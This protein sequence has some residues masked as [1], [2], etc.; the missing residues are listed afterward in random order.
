MKNQDVPE[1]IKRLRSEVKNWRTTTLTEIALTGKPFLVLVSCV[2]SLRTKDET[3]ADACKRLFPLANTPAEIIELGQEKLAE[4]IYPVGFY[5]NKAASIIDNCKNIIERYD[6]KTPDSIEELLTL[7]GVGRKTANLVITLG[8]GKPGICVDIHVHRIFNRLGY[9][10][11]KTP[12]ETESV[13]RKKLP[14]EYWIESN[15]LLVAFGQNHCHPISPRCSTCRISEFCKRIGV[16][17][18][19]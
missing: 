7:K 12:D 17:K 9:I 3:T 8:F 4:L 2:L 19:R 6:G 16:T 15:D 11:T 1:V 5:N 14:K 13:L 18:H 10:E